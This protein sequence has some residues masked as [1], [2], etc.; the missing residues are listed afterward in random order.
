MVVAH[1]PYKAHKVQRKL[2]ISILVSVL[3]TPLCYVCQVKAVL[4]STCESFGA[5][6]VMGKLKNRHLFS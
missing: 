2:L 3:L 6:R 4:F 5:L 1:L